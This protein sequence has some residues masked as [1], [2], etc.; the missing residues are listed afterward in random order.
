MDRAIQNGP[1]FRQCFFVEVASSP[2]VI[3]LHL[4]HRQLEANELP[5]I[6]I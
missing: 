1:I 3:R 5:Q 2:G 4:Y 6:P